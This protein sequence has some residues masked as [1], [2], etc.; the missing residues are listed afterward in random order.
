MRPYIWTLFQWSPI[1][2]R[3]LWV[4]GS[5]C[6]VPV[7]V[8]VCVSVSVSVCNGGYHLLIYISTRAGSY[9]TRF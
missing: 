8:S 6:G 1:E 2:I 4:S 9:N 7:S 5:L 3:L